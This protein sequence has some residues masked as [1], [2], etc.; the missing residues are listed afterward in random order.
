MI[1]VPT[2]HTHIFRLSLNNVWYWHVSLCRLKDAIVS[3]EVS[4]DTLS[5]AFGCLDLLRST[6]HAYN[7]K[8]AEVSFATFWLKFVSQY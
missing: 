2:F 7:K 4:T 8:I 6:L 3:N 5:Y 1:L